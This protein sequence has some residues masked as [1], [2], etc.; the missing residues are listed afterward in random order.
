MNKLE[1]NKLRRKMR[2][3]RKISGT[4]SRPRLS[5]FRSLNKIY[6]QL[7][8]DTT[9]TT[10]AAASSLSKEI[11]N[12]LKETKGKIAQSV[13]VGKL[14]AKKAL[15]ANITSAVFD[16]NGFKYHGRIK[17]LADGTR[18]GGLKI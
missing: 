13:I 14:L 18:E 4:A 16:R 1:V 9:G 7:I 6:A 8:D 10:L 3:R 2:I 5:V 11:E 17:A 12:E 15:E